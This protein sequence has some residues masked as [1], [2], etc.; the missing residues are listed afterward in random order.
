MPDMKGAL[1]SFAERWELARGETCGLEESGEKMMTFIIPELPSCY[2]SLI[3]GDGYDGTS[4]SSGVAS[5]SSKKQSHNRDFSGSSLDV[6]RNGN[7]S[8]RNASQSTGIS[9]HV[10]PPACQR[11]TR[12]NLTYELVTAADGT[13]LGIGPYTP[14]SELPLT[15][16]AKL[17]RTSFWHREPEKHFRRFWAGMITDAD[18]ERLAASE[19]GL[20]KLREEIKGVHDGRVCAGEQDLAQFA[21]EKWGNLAFYAQ[22]EEVEK[23]KVARN[24]RAPAAAFING[25]DF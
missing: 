23:L 3:I 13:I 19:S 2:A 21:L 8:S 24:V 6:S 16:V 14:Y 12:K 10:A 1:L 18:E 15:D 11:A 25:M 17:Q 4:S 22:L 5:C 9:S 7:S 20:Q